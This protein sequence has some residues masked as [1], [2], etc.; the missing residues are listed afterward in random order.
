MFD[1]SVQSEHVFVFLKES[2][3]HILDTGRYQA[4][5]ESLDSNYVSTN[6]PLQF[7]LKKQVID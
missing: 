3:N 7:S 1:Y 2:T 5:L 6:Q 4:I